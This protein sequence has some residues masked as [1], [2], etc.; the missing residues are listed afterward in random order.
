MNDTLEYME[1]DPVHRAFHH[2]LLTF[3]PMYAYAE[4]F[5][6]P[7]SHDEVVH[8]KGSLLW[9]MPGDEW[10]KFANLR[11]LYGY[12]AAVPGKKL[13]FMGG[14]I[15]QWSE[16]DHDSSVQ[17]H[18]LEGPFH[19]GMRRWVAHLNRLHSEEA[20]LHALDFDPSGFEWVDFRDSPQSVISFLRKSP[21][22]RGEI[23]LAVF[24]FTPVPRRAYRVGAP[25]GGVWREIANGDAL[26]YGGSGVG[27]AGAATAEAVPRH[28]RPFSLALDLPPL[29]ALFLKA[30][31]EPEPADPS[32]EVAP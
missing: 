22:D 32:R 24:N 31:E 28:G 12:Q 8:L 6:L 20:A 10:Q 13:L 17:W 23:V 19:S 30:P 16:W 5:V 18:L 11:L 25:R 9:K 29:A 27:N 14:E 2:G 4:N 21:A 1:L 7:L 15:G 26:E 3:R